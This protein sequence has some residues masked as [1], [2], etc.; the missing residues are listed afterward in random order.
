MRDVQL[1]LKRL[2]FQS[3]LPA[4]GATGGRERKNKTYPNFNPRSPR[5]ERLR[6]LSSLI[7]LYNFNPRSPR[8]ERQALGTTRRRAPLFQSTL[9]AGGA[10][11]ESMGITSLNI[12]FQST[13]PAGGAT[14]MIM[15]CALMHATFQST[16][17][18]GGA[19]E[20]P[21]IINPVVQ[22]QSTLPA[23]GATRTAI[24]Y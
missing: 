23:G 3:T 2:R 12:L 21:V 16:L 11:T 9:P 13:L 7:L 14:I 5:G 15:Q 10:T 6:P 1:F 19:T 20:S 18:A 22:F 17:P 24:Y 4:G 8:G